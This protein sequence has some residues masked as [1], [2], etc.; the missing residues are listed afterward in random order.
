MMNFFKKDD[1]KTYQ[2]HSINFRVNSEDKTRLSKQAE[3][4]NISLSEHVR[5]KALFENDNMQSIMDE[6]TR[7]KNQIKDY[8]AQIESENSEDME[9]GSITIK[10][11]EENKKLLKCILSFIHWNRFAEH[12]SWNE[13]DLVL[14]KAFM[15][16]MIEYISETALVEMRGLKRTH[17]IYTIDDLYERFAGFYLDV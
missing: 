16:C 6:N 17:N 3:K 7:L 13:S 10:I 8:E 15:F 2:Y 9:E 5:N 4:L 1:P 12:P 11:S 14:S